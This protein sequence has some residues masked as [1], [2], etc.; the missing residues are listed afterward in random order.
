MYGFKTYEKADTIQGA[1][2]CLRK[3]PRARL[4]AGGTD[5][6]IRL[7][8]GKTA[9]EHLVD[10]HDVEEIKGITRDPSGR[11]R[12]GAGATFTEIMESEIILNHIPVLAVAVET[13]GGPQI[14]NMATIGGNIC[15]GVPSADSASSLFVLNAELTV[16]GGEGEKRMHIS[17]FYLGPGKVNLAQDEVLTGFMV[18]PE[19]Y[20]GYHGHFIKYAM[21][22]AMDIA[23]IGCAALL[24]L[25]QGVVND[26]RLCFGVAGPVPLRCKTVEKKVLGRKPDRKLIDDVKHTVMTDLKPRDSWRASRDFRVQIIRELAGRVVTKTIENAGGEVS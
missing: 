19:N 8:E 17:D 16:M 21:R 4:L 26:L 12:I 14:R 11:I 13:I 25:H 3:N 7:R 15:N 18:S 24:E 9:F 5:V 1:I 23:T 20:T 6:L 22:D 10:I 2:E